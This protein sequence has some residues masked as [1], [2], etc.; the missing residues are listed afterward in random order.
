MNKNKINVLMRKLNDALKSYGI[1]SVISFDE[2]K[3]DGI[4]RNGI[5]LFVNTSSVMP[6]LYL[7]DS[8]YERMGDD[9]VIQF[10]V[11]KLNSME[12]II[13]IY[14]IFGENLIGL[15]DKLIAV[16]INYEGNKE[17]LKRVPYERFYDMAV[18]LKICD[19]DEDEEKYYSFTNDYF[20]SMNIDK[21][22]LFKRAKYNT[23]IKYGS[24]ITPMSNVLKG[25]DSFKPE[26]SDDLN[27]MSFFVNDVYL[28]TNDHM[29]YGA[30]ILLYDNIMRSIYDILK[31]DYY[32]IL[33]NVHEVIILP[34]VISENDIRVFYQ[35]VEEV[36]TYT[37]NKNEILS[38]GILYYDHNS[39]DIR[40]VS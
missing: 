10:F 27:I 6:V 12:E 8:V 11:D 39:D 33:A 23:E 36:N 5:T 13:N 9:G 20:S 19:L 35:N 2:L 40:M 38:H 1:E 21:E 24:I 37:L 31:N 7:D 4:T 29:Y 3:N 28:G 32:I 34:A 22:E 16:L 30:S 15:E 26:N 18:V 17:Y 25:G 14:E